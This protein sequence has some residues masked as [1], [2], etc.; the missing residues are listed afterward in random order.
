MIYCL[1]YSLPLAYHISSNKHQ[2]SDKGCPLISTAP[3]TLRSE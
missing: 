2:A 3:L 1:L